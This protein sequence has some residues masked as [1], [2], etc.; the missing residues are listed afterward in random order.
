[1]TQTTESA[2]ETTNSDTPSESELVAPKVPSVPV[3]IETV[4]VDRN[5]N[6]DEMMLSRVEPDI[7]GPAFTISEVSL[8]FFSR[9]RHWIL[10]LEKTGMMV[11]PGI[12]GEPDEVLAP[13]RSVSGA[14]YY[15]L[16]LIEKI[17]HALAAHKKIDGSQL[18]WSLSL[19]R[20]QAEM[21]GLIADELQRATP[22]EILKVQKLVQKELVKM[23]ERREKAAEKRRE[24]AAEK[25]AEALVKKELEKLANKRRK[26]RA[27]A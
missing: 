10:W 16:V 8:F 27:R 4:L 7:E 9:S 1:M 3:S 2:E 19:I 17:S 18:Y 22:A 14:R 24:K 5:I 20:V 11:L 6:P 23:S 21:H 25:K 26:M 13:L 12:N 15:D